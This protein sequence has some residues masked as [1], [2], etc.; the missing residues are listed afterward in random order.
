M[1][2]EFLSQA[3]SELIDAVAYY[4]GELGRSAAAFGLGW[5]G[6][7]GCSARA[8]L[9]MPIAVAT[10]AQTSACAFMVS[11]DNFW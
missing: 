8:S 9:R 10:V 5:H 3:K 1:I 4:E 6:G 7:G 11:S 2:V